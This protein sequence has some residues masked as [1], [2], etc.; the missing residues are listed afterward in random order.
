MS[1]SVTLTPQNMTEAM[2][3][4]KML[5]QS[6]MVP[7]NF[8]G[9]PQDCLV[10]MQWG[11][12]VGLQPM[13][14]LQNIAV[15]NGKPSIWG[16][17]ALALV[18]SHPDCK[19]VNEKIEG[20]GD[21]MRAVCTVKRAHGDE[22]EETVRTFSVANA[23]TARLWGKQG[24]WTNYPERM[25]GARARG[26]ALRDAFPD[27]LKGIITR[28]EAEDIPPPKNITPEKDDNNFQNQLDKIGAPES[29]EQE[30]VV[31]DTGEV[32]EDAVEGSEDQQSYT[33][34]LVGRTGQQIEQPTTDPE[35]YGNNLLK[36][37]HTA[38]LAE[39][40]RNGNPINERDRMSLLKQL[41]EAN[42]EGIDQ[43]PEDIKQIVADGYRKELKT[44]GAK[45]NGPS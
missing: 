31:V 26:F 18:R 27:A 23:K 9:K 12:E 2:D 36:M 33:F 6:G 29:D 25:L 16:D 22:I 34:T 3:F 4:A 17:A 28:E 15:I 44:L 39:R 41:K 8:K 20:E 11:F 38:A 10:A 5:A 14:A 42:Q 19:G 30:T 7:T 1:K 40:D 37:F 32:I 13:Q 43:M 21:Q 45:L 24:P 35:V